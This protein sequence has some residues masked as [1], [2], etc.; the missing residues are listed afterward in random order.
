M[1]ITVNEILNNYQSLSG[2]IVEI[3]G[4]LGVN[5]KANIKIIFDSE[6]SFFDE[7]KYINILCIDLDSILKNI[8]DVL[9]YG[10]GPLYYFEMCKLKGFLKIIDNKPSINMVES[11][12]VFVGN[13]KKPVNII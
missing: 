4:Y 13:K 8:P 11:L 12:I 9:P 1:I 6:E 5:A 3:K 2:N 10:G 7:H